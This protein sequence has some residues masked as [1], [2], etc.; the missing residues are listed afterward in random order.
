M[1]ACQVFG[2]ALVGNTRWWRPSP[3]TRKTSWAWHSSR[4]ATTRPYGLAGTKTSAVMTVS[5]TLFTGTPGLDIPGA[6][7]IP[8]LSRLH[9][10]QVL[11]V[12]DGAVF[13]EESQY[14]HSAISHKADLDTPLRLESFSGPDR[15][16]SWRTV[17]RPLARATF[18]RQTL[19]NKFQHADSTFSKHNLGFQGDVYDAFHGV[20]EAFGG[21]SGESFTGRGHHRARFEVSLLM[22]SPAPHYSLHRRTEKT[23]RKCTKASRRIN[24]ELHPNIPRG[25][26]PIRSVK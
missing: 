26:E 13:C 7:P 1:L 9:K 10:E 2:S 25:P 20:E 22:N 6:G 18:N 12:Y 21:V 8:S 3:G 14:E 16:L 15:S 11:W 24:I 23:T 4:H 5:W 19:W 17:D